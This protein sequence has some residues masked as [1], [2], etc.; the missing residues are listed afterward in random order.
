MPLKQ[1]SQDP[2]RPRDPQPLTPSQMLEQ[3]RQSMAANNHLQEAS[4]T[5]V[6]QLRERRAE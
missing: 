2:S 5:L 3:L 6:Q 1:L 4:K